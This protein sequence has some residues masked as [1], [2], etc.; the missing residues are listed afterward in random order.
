M[1]SAFG[2]N[3][4]QIGGPTGAFIVIVYGIIARFGVEGL[5]VATLMAG[6]ILVL[7]GLFRLG[8]VIKFIP[9]PIVIGFTAGIALTIFSTQINDFLGLGLS[10]L[11]S[12]FLPKM[13]MYL[14]NLHLIDPTTLA[15][16][17]TTLAI[18]I[19][20]PKVSKRLPGALIAIVVMTTAVWA[21]TS[22]G[23]IADIPTCLL[24]TSRCV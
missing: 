5:A 21:M 16:G 20:T 4:V 14:R 10:G 13:G 11:P 9:Y 8:T 18:I 1:V 17:L 15:V 3:S 22:Q 12:E 7:M 6:L 2:G 19:L 23:I 24:Y